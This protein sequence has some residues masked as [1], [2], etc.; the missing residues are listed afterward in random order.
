MKAKEKPAPQEES[1]SRSL[2]KEER[3][4]RA[5]RLPVPQDG[6]AIEVGRR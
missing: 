6:K 2:E 3:E 4:P 5:R 1:I